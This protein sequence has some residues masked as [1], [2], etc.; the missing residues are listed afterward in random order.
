MTGSVS[1]GYTRLETTLQDCADQCYWDKRCLSFEYCRDN[2][3]DDVPL[4]PYKKH[5]SLNEVVEPNTSGK[6]NF[7]FCRPSS[8]NDL[9]TY[10]S[11][12]FNMY[13]TLND[14]YSLLLQFFSCNNIVL[15]AFLQNH[16]PPTGCALEIRK[17]FY[18]FKN[19]MHN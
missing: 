6:S 7:I 13:F 18:A 3:I 12:T 9:R 19:L 8:M 1:T 10:S 4:T 11:F 16:I 15:Q 5:C 14:L 17:N 2:C